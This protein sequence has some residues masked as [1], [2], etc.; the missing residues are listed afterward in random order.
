MDTESTASEE[1]LIR[2]PL[3]LALVD[4][5]EWPLQLLYVPEMRSYRRQPDNIYRDVREP[6]Y[7][8]LSYTWGRWHLP[9]G[10]A[11]PVQSVTWKVPPVSPRAFTV[12]ELQRVLRNVAGESGWVWVDIACIDQEVLEVK[13]NQIGKQA[14]IF[15]NANRAFIWLHQ[16]SLGELERLVELLFK[17]QDTIYDDPHDTTSTAYSQNSTLNETSG[18]SFLS[19]CFQD[20]DWLDAVESSLRIFSDPWF[21]SLWTLQ[22]SF[23]RP[24][25]IV[26]SK[27]AQELRRSDGTGVCLTDFS[28]T[29]DD[30]RQRIS[31]ELMYHGLFLPTHVVRRL[32]EIKSR[33]ERLHMDATDNPIALYAAAASRSTMHE[34]DRIYGIMQV[35][36]LRLGKSKYPHQEFSLSDLE[37][38]FTAALAETSPI[39]GQLFVHTKPPAPH[40]HWCVS[41]SSRRPARL[42]TGLPV[43][44]SSCV[45]ALEDGDGSAKVPFFH[46]PS[47]SFQSLVALW[48]RMRGLMGYAAYKARGSNTYLTRPVQLIALDSSQFVLANVYTNPRRHDDEKKVE[49]KI[50][51]DHLVERMGDDLHVFRLGE[52]HSLDALGEDDY[53]DDYEDEDED[54]DEDGTEVDDEDQ[55]TWD[56]AVCVGLLVRQ[57]PGSSPL[58]QRI[59]VA[60][61]QSVPE[62]ISR[63]AG[64][65]DTRAYLD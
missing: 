38:E 53:E 27:E 50:L 52:L 30:I 17:S 14:S 19:P 35:F 40:R 41:Q 28:L 60:L 45:I 3:D 10:D 8:I 61:W 23:L 59:G 64:W 22:E 36:G 16:S 62:S 48:D 56:D 25:A 6:S 1:S 12:D 65:S 34:E 26:L 4:R 32:E 47:C 51:P 13:M 18:T 11:L 42:E 49:D 58:W 24:E 43:P 39:L 15:S 44:K 29:L 21:S 33:I 2:D 5:S 63:E 20:T 31:T 57:L 46:G 9:A 37:V 55:D 54:R 7:N